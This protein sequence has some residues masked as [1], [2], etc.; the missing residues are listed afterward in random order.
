MKILKKV[1]LLI[2]GGALVLVGMILAVFVGINSFQG[3]PMFNIGKFIFLG[4]VI[5]CPMILGTIIIILS[6][7]KENK[8]KIILV[9]ESVMLFMYV[10]IIF[11]LVFGGFRIFQSGHNNQSILEYIKFNSNFIPFK[12]IYN[13]FSIYFAGHINMSIVIENLL[14]NFMMFMPMGFL[15]PAIFKK[16]NKWFLFLAT[17]A[18]ML[19]GIEVAQLIFRLGSFD[20]DDFILNMAGACLI[21]AIIRKGIIKKFLNRMMLI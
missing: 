6:V 9:A 16:Q 12:T 18:S 11:I 4:G 3:Q 21:F 15:L 14:G 19:L 1:V 20:I 8:R 2:V 10:N 5:A 17:L 7:K 13:Y